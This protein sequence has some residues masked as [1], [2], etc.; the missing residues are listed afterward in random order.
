M[1]GEKKLKAGKPTTPQSQIFLNGPR[2]G[3]VERVGMFKA[4]KKEVD[5]REPL[6]PRREHGTSSAGNSA[7]CVTA[8]D[9]IKV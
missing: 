3:V 9:H 5:R 4:R 6:I 2:K 8:A 1:T 7:K